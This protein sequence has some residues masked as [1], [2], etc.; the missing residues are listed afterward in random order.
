MTGETKR[1][2]AIAGLGITDVGKVYGRTAR[3]FAAD[4][5]RRAC[6]DAGLLTSELDGLLV[7]P[8]LN[9]DLNASLAEDLGVRDLKLLN[10]S[11]SDGSSVCA[12]IAYAS[13]AISAGLANTIAC[14]FA[15][16]PLR[17]GHRA[18]AAYAPRESPRGFDSLVAEAGLAN[19][20]AQY[21]LATRR[22]METFGTTSEQLGAIAVAQRAWASR[23]PLAQM[24]EPIR[25]VDHQSSRLVADPLRLLDCCLVSNG[26][27]AVV[28]TSAS[29]AAALA[30]PPVYILGFA[31]SHPVHE[32]AKGSRFGIVSGAAE[33]GPAAL[34]MAGADIEDVGIAEIYDCFTF[35][36]LLTLEDYG[37]CP[38]GEGGLYAEEGH[39]MPGGGRT[40]VNTGGGQLSGYYMWGMTPV[41]EAVIQARGV[42]GDRQ[43][44]HNELIMV[45]GNGGVLHH[46]STL[47]LSP[48][49]PS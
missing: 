4:A 43:V 46:H 33:S 35:A 1:N 24:R 14:V 8:G 20:H 26:G 38:R 15:D 10:V 49:A 32:D 44:D 30:Q 42:G 7:T 31:Q 11:R 2:A 21:A 18:G 39:L 25:L 12:A 9:D 40:A 29:R 28:V 27:V 36:V 17:R 22:H 45:S 48:R 6:D 47:V 34:H 23:N 41:S 19:V 16:A 3:D 37:F 13:M 5:V